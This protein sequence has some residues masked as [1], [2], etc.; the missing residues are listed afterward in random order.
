MDSTHFNAPAGSLLPGDPAPWFEA[1]TLA[2]ASV[3]LGVVAGRWVVLCFLNRLASEISTR[4]LAELLAEAKLFQDDHMVFYGVVTEPPAEAQ[5]LAQVSHPALGFIADFMGEISRAYGALGSSRLIV[6]NPLLQL[7]ANFPIAADGPSTETLRKFLRDLPA[8]DQFAG[9]GLC[10]PALIVPHV[11][12]PQICEFLISLYEKHGGSESGFM[13]DQNGKTATIVDHRLKSRRDFI[14]IDP[15]VRE[16]IR[17]RVVRRLL[18]MIERFFQYRPTR[19]DRYMVSCYDAESSGHFSRH[20]DNLNA[21]ARHRR[22][23]V[24]INLNTGY[25]GCDL[26]FPEFGRRLYRAPFGG[27]VVFS[28]GAL[29]QVTPVTRGKRYAFVPFLYGEEEAR[30]RLANNALLAA[31]EGLYSGEHDRLF[32]QAAE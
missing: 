3:N 19:M 27:A 8:I 22:F 28:T 32:P 6:L 25:E 12:E 30:Q 20:R 31:G 29:H 24:S 4:T 17:S 11:F 15:E 18:P 1:N 21:G 16:M 5:Q 13:L 23:A 14:V 2:G 26:I 9:V 10:A 7:A